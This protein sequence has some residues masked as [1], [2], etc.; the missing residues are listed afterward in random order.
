MEV[1]DNTNKDEEVE[2]TEDN[3]KMQEVLDYMAVKIINLDDPS[4]CLSCLGGGGDFFEGYNLAR[5]P[6][7]EGDNEVYLRGLN[8]VGIDLDLEY[9]DVLRQGQS[10]GYIKRPV[11]LA[12]PRFLQDALARADL[13]AKLGIF[14]DTEEE[15]SLNIAEY[16]FFGDEIARANISNLR[17]PKNSTSIKNV[18][19]RQYLQR[20]ENIKEGDD[21]RKA[22]D[23]A[24]D[25]YKWDNSL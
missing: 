24:F 4:I 9:E 1:F 6:H 18:I 25:L 7:I 21:I 2:M 5:D 3:K 15:D 11:D 16:N 22:I 19:P 20:I 23:V 13:E 17:D 14:C 10:H 8:G 12:K